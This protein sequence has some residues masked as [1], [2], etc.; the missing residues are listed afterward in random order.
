M[1]AVGL[2][3]LSKAHARQGAPPGVTALARVGDVTVLSRDPQD[4]DSELPHVRGEG[5]AG[6]A[7][8]DSNLALGVKGQCSNSKKKTTK[9]EIDSFK[10]K[11][12]WRKDISTPF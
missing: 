8:H 5:Q 9:Q 3:L 4:L 10:K 12:P 6:I 2:G 7:G 11:V 1:A